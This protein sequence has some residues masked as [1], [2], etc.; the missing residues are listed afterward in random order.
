MLLKTLDYKRDEVVG[1]P[2]ISIFGETQGKDL[3]RSKSRSI[4]ISKADG[5]NIR[6]HKNPK[7]R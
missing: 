7:F 3:I 6:I 1:K 4:Q 2:I 5:K